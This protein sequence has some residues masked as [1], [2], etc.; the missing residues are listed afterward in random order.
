MKIIFH[1]KKSIS[2]LTVHVSAEANNEVEVE[3]LKGRKAS[4]ICE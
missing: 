1:H 4:G 2:N 3:S